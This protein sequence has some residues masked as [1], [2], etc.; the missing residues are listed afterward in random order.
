MVVLRPN[1][2]TAQGDIKAPIPK[3]STGAELSDASCATSSFKLLAISG[4]SGPIAATGPRRITEIIAME[5][6]EIAAT[7]FGCLLNR[8]AFPGDQLS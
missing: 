6:T 7:N 2:R 5:T 8:H 1:L 4:K 3:H